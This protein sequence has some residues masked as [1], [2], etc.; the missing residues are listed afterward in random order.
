MGLL[1]TSRLRKKIM[2]TVVQTIFRQCII[3]MWSPHSVSLRRE[4][5][6]APRLRMTIII[7]MVFIAMAMIVKV[8]WLRMTMI[9]RLRKTII[10]TVVMMRCLHTVDRADLHATETV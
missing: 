4:D 8:R 7:R 1:R 2:T 10:V 6:L 3:K 5:T 9:I